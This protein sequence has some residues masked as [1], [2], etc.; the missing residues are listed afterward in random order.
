MSA[1]APA[2]GAGSLGRRIE[3]WM[4]GIHA[5]RTYERSWLSRDLIAGVVLVTLLVPQGMAYAE[6]AG[7]PAITGL[8]TTVVCLIAYALVGPSP[9]LVLGPDSSLGPMIAATILPLAAGSQEMAI[10]LAGMLA[11]MVGLVTIGAGIAK[12]GFIA[13]LLSN[14]VRT[15]YLAGLAITIFVGQLP[16]L[17]GFSTDASG[18]ANEVSAFVAGVQDGLTNPWALGIGLLSLVI[19]L[20]LKRARPR[21]PGI[22][23][24]VVV[25]IGLSIVLDLA[26]RDV[27]VVGVLPQGFPLPTFPAV[28]TEDLLV[29]FAAAVGISLVAIGDTI[30]VSGG[31]SAR[32][33]YEVDGNQELAGIG[34]ANLAA[35]LFS[36]FPVSTSG[37][38]TAVAFQ[39]GAKSQLTGLVAATLVIAMLLFVPGLVQAMPQPVLAAVVIAASISLFDVA[40]LRNLYA[41]R[42][43]EFALAVACALGVMFIGVLEGI[44]V[45]VALSVIYIFKRAWQPYSTVLGRPAD[46]PGYHDIRRYP[47]A[48]QEPG[49][50]IVRWSAPLFFANATVFRDR[51]RE[52]VR[53]SDPAP[54]WVLIAAEPITDIDT[55]AGSVLRDLDLELNAAG[56]HLAFAELQSDVRDAIVRYGLLET[57]DRGHIYPSVTEAVKA[58]RREVAR[59]GAVDT[60]DPA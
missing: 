11:L 30:S 50:L 44:V 46:V 17:F 55:T 57:I 5:L 21:T 40:E 31:F 54:A 13:D 18:L 16:K 25:S 1:A 47:D 28:P 9:I 4:P 49:L 22:L 33:G 14:P 41:I 32:A 56:I 12:L 37:S 34:S 23:I 35:G 19:I 38:R 39:S 42:R 36:G 10:A 29:L 2:Q 27:D 45:A 15:G 53:A 20:G 52:L 59:P 7:L 24:A 48:D 3:H 60:A 8:Y 58:Y 26:S 43:T 6:L 51:V